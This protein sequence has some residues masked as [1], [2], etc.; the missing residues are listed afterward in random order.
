MFFMK[1]K[2]KEIFIIWFLYL[3]LNL[4]VALTVQCACIIP[5]ELNL[6]SVSAYLSGQ[7]W[8]SASSSYT[9]YY[10]YL[11]SIL[12]VPLF[13]I[14][15]DGIILFKSII[16]LNS[17]IVSFIPLFCY[18][19]L[20][21]TFKVEN[22]PVLIAITIMS[23][24]QP[25]YLT[26][27]K[28][29]W[30]ETMVMFLT[31][32][33][34]YIFSLLISKKEQKRSYLL[35]SLLGCTLAMGYMTHGRFLAI[36]M[37]SIIVVITYRILYKK[38]LYNIGICYGVMGIFLI[39]DIFI[40]KKVM[41]LL[42]GID[43]VAT[44]NTF[45][46]AIENIKLS[47]I[48]INT[49][50]DVL[51]AFS[52]DLFYLIVSS[53]GILLVG[54]II[55]YRIIK[56]LVKPNVT[57][58][59]KNKLINSIVFGSFI[60][61]SILIALAI[62]AAFFIS[63]YT[64]VESEYFFIYGRYTEY[65][66]GPL[67]LITGVNLYNYGIRKA[68]V[69]LSFFCFSISCLYTFLLENNDLAKKPWGQLNHYTLRS[70]APNFDLET[71]QYSFLITILIFIIFFSILLI[72][73]AKIKKVIWAYT[74][75][76]IIFICSYVSTSHYAIIHHSRLTFTRIENTYNFFETIKNE[77][78]YKKYKIGLYEGYPVSYQVA[79]PDFK[80]Y[81]IPKQEVVDAE[82]FII[83]PS[84]LPS[85]KDN[86]QLYEIKF[87]SC[88][89]DEKICVYGKGLAEKLNLDGFKLEPIVYTLGNKINFNSD[90]NILFC[91]LYNWHGKENWGVWSNGNESS[92]KINLSEVHSDELETSITM[93]TYSSNKKV[94]IFA[95]EFK[96]GTVTL[97]S[98][99]K[100]FDFIIPKNIIK[101]NQIEIKF[102]ILD[103][104]VSPSEMESST[105][106]R[107]LGIGLTNIILK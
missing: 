65:L 15:K 104:V 45:S 50:H 58:D 3:I 51:R 47:G 22:K 82:C 24:V 92:I 85:V 52:G 64:K 10:G 17:I 12:Y 48:N 79:L 43:N 55:Y 76:I 96:I 77:E 59:E 44:S 83:T 97:E 6:L 101:S 31:W 68:E 49:L 86:T 42:F 89:S 27:S 40:R 80:F 1:N 106:T 9:N 26:M 37:A 60:L 20:K 25:A 99:P 2:S 46:A 105:D 81:V 21:N 56:K 70:F 87:N 57:D 66:L 67:L 7:N 54:I 88:E 90:G 14:F 95:N 102:K 5:D 62:N 73:L 34:F 38:Y 84:G 30:S 74:F 13:L 4:A 23:A 63:E 32:V 36:I 29:A 107:K 75:V 19:I 69:I 93:G 91:T 28:H 41:L 33:V 8:Q 35:D 94:E 16:C 18:K 78:L 39:I 71:N 103:K 100:E 11:Q 98:I 72:L 61:L 53:I